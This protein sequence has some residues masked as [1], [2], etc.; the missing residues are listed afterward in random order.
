[1]LEKMGWEDGKG[2]G[3]KLEGETEFIKIDKRPDN[4]GLF[5]FYCYSACR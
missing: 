3:A 2:L 4:R 1:M 5:E